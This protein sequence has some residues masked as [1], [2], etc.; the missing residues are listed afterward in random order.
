MT[1]ASTPKR[2]KP[3]AVTTHAVVGRTDV[4]TSSA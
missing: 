4:G 1:V 2:R 3:F